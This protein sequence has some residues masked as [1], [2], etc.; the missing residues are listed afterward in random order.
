MV[1]KELENWKK[2]WLLENLNIV[3]TK[4]MCGKP[5]KYD[6]LTK[7]SIVCDNLVNDYY[8][9]LLG[10]L[11]NWMR[12]PTHVLHGPKAGNMMVEP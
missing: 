7:D 8:A 5:H 10:D 12:H 4:N 9:L 6:K 2:T 3:V 1:E 11:I